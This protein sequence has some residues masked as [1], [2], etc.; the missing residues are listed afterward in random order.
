MGPGGAESRRLPMEARQ[1]LLHP[2]RI[3]LESLGLAG[4][5]VLKARGWESCSLCLFPFNHTS[6]CNLRQAGEEKRGRKKKEKGKNSAVIPASASSSLSSPTSQEPRHRHPTLAS[7]LLS[8]ES[9]P[10]DKLQ[11]S[12]QSRDRKALGWESENSP[13]WKSKQG[14]H[15]AWQG[16][17]I[18]SHGA[19]ETELCATRRKGSVLR[20]KGKLSPRRPFI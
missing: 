5:C 1:T 6:A 2:W 4:G 3:S 13:R 18:C 12:A 8:L 19:G 7:G 17:G 15:P 20:E 11:L 9:S 14:R 16:K 10:G